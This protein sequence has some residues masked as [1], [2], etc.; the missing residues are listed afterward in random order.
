MLL[1]KT[2]MENTLRFLF[3]RRFRRGQTLVEY[4][5]ILAFIAV[6]AIG[7]LTALGGTTRNVY[8]GVSV[9]L[10]TAQAGGVTGGTSH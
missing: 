8:A 5:L 3:Q 2:S 9:Q 10:T 6:V 4:A 1:A 7:V